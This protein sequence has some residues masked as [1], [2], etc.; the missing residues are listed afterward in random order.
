MRI[1]IDVEQLLQYIVFSFICNVYA[2]A[3]D[4]LND[5]RLATCRLSYLALLAT[6]LDKYLITH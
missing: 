2:L 6:T 5:S 3:D 4:S 1:S